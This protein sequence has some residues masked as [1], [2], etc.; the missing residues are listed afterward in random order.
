[1]LKLH[2]A[3]KYFQLKVCAHGVVSLVLLGVDFYLQI[4]SFLCFN[5]CRTFENGAR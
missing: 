2:V 1:M 4:K 3:L 5:G